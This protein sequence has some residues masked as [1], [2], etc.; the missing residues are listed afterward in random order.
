[1][2]EQTLAVYQRALLSRLVAGDAPAQ[3]RQAL[4]D[5]PALAPHAEYIYSLDDDALRV[6]ARLVAK[7]GTPAPR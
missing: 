6:A 5:E 2:D 7:W 4:L 1:M 3:I